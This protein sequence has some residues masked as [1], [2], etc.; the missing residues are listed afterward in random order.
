MLG[1]TLGDV[2]WILYGYDE[3][4]KDFIACLCERL[5]LVHTTFAL[6]WAFLQIL[7]YFININIY[8]Y[9]IFHIFV[10]MGRIG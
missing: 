9:I 10:G 1:D 3:G 7:V 8:I 5:V 6:L 4:S 2:A